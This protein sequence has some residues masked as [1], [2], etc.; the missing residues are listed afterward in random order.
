MGNLLPEPVAGDKKE[1]HQ[2]QK[3]KPGKPLQSQNLWQKTLEKI[4]D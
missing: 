1:Q 3:S 4:Q 2:K